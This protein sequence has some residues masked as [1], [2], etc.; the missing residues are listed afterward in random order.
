MAADS[1][2]FIDTGNAYK[3]YAVAEHIIV[4]IVIVVTGVVNHY[5]AYFY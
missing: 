5:A 3:I 2:N 1:L 4:N